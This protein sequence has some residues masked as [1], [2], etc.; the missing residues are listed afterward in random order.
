[1]VWFSQSEIKHLKI[2]LLIGRNISLTQTELSYFQ[3]HKILEKKTN[4][5]LQNAWWIWTP[6]LSY[7]GKNIVEETQ[8]HHIHLITFGR[9][10]LIFNDKLYPM[11]NLRLL[12]S[13][14][15]LV[16]GY[17]HFLLFR[18]CIQK[19]FSSGSLI[20][21]QTTNFTC[22]QTERAFRQQFH[23]W[24]KWQKLPKWEENTAGKGEIARSEQFLL[25]PQCFQKACTADT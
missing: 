24:W 21:S 1:M 18:Q 5:V 3:I 16:F 17:Q 19:V 7:K 23:I 10:C 8:K 15:V 22:F 9:C 20:L 4:N 14:I 2:T 6:S 12:Q 11:I 13:G 25:S